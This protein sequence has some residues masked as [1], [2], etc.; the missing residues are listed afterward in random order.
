[1]SGGSYDYAYARIRE[2]ADD[3]RPTTAL[4]KAFKR[5]LHEVA[6]ACEDIEWVDSG[7]CKGGDENEA[8]RRVL[9]Q[10]GPA[11]I[12]AEA[13]TEALQAQ[14]DLNAAIA[15]MKQVKKEKE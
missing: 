5:H 4:R 6:K 13:L 3:I 1:M 15:E 9:G 12:L 2:L 11:L 10:N 7:D 8:I 14:K